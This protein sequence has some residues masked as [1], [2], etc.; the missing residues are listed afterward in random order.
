METV[1][2]GSSD[3]SRFI[4]GGNPF[5]GSSSGH[6][7][8]ADKDLP[9]YYTCARIKETYRQAESLGVTTAVARADAHILRVLMEYW[10]EGGTIQWIGQT[11]PELDSHERS[12]DR[13][14]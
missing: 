7:R 6:G 2:I 8:E 11:C 1:R 10:D 14:S 13:V 12:L 9:H 3:V 5:S 4:I